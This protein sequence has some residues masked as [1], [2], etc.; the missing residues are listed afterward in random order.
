[1]ITNNYTPYSG[2]VVSSIDAIITELRLQGHDVIIV[3]LDFAGS[4]LQQNVIRISSLV[5]FTY[6]TNPMALPWQAT[7]VLDNIIAQYKPDIIHT[8]HPFL[9]GVSA[10]RA[11]R[12][13]RAPILFTHHTLYDRYAHY[14]PLPQQITNWVIGKRVVA[15]CNA[16]D[17][18]IAPSN[19]V[20]NKL[21]TEGVTKPIACLP[22]PL[23]K[24]YERNIDVFGDFSIHLTTLKLRKVT[25]SDRILS[26]S[27][28]LPL[29]L[30]SVSR[31]TPEKNVYA[32]LD[33]YAILKQ[34]N[35]SCVLTLIG[36]GAE[37]QRLR[38]YAR[39]HLKLLPHEIIFIIKPPKEIIARYYRAAD[40]FIFASQTETQGL[41]VAEAMAA[42][43]PVV[44]FKGPGVDECVVDG[45]N[46]YL[47]TTVQDMAHRICVLANDK[48]LLEQLQQGALQTAVNYHSA[49]IVQKL[50]DYYRACAR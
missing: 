7:K 16:V 37:E 17:M 14:V 31:F 25:R 45:V 8:H 6:R 12:N 4:I 39:D 18:V 28:R 21:V 42:G 49:T 47:V 50:V 1:M 22:S 13:T 46:G 9:L 11:A 36:F 27:L 40:L 10:L 3:T 35:V 38:A 32:L 44:A 34:K 33:A 20:K 29:H 30:L 48:L 5:R 19:F 24:I 23:L 26:R 15:Y 43:T 2:G 41:V